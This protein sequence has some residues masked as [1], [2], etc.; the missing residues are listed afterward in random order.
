MAGRIFGLAALTALS[1]GLLRPSAR[2]EDLPEIWAT[3]PPPPLKADVKY[4]GGPGLIP[5]NRVFVSCGTNQFTFLVPDGFR[6]DASDPRKLTLVN[7]DFTCL[8]TWRVLGPVP[9]QEAGPDQSFYREM[10]LKRHPGGKILEEFSLSAL[11]RYG[12]AF[13]LRWGGAGGLARRERLLFIPTLAGIV[14]FD[15]VSSLE[16]FGA[17]IQQ[18][19]D[20]LVNFRASDEHGKLVVP[21]ISNRI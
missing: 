10:L 8:I 2:A 17:R 7:A 19:N 4:I 18:F 11:G 12:P 6:L 13:D 5:V 15:L 1:L 3:N 16:T 20:V 14:E 21:M 9:T